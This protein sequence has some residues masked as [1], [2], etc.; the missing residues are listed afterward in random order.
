MFAIDIV[1][2]FPEIPGGRKPEESTSDEKMARMI[3][4]S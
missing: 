4:F 3:I 2:T 1:Y